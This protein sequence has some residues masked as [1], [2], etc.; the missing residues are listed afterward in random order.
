MT[1]AP[2]PPGGGPP[3]VPTDWRHYPHQVSSKAPRH[4]GW[5]PRRKWIVSLSVWSSIAALWMLAGFVSGY[6][7]YWAALML[8]P[9]LLLVLSRCVGLDRVKPAFLTYLLGITPAI[10]FV[11]VD[12]RWPIGLVILVMIASYESALT[13][14]TE[15]KYATSNE[16]VPE[17]AKHRARKVSLLLITVDAYGAGLDTLVFILAIVAVIRLG[18]LS[19]VLATIAIGLS[20]FV[21][22]KTGSPS[23][24][25]GLGQTGFTGPADE[26]WFFTFETLMMATALWGGTAYRT[27]TRIR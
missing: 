5:T 3:G 17:L 7:L 6:G 4:T 14:G 12:W 15:L 1:F 21:F 2:F 24:F 8:G 27:W 11:A 25:L 22:L 19:V 20:F 13:S 18:R 26:R 9:T 16:I 23:Y 10:A